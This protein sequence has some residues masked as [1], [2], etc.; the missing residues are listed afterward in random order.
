MDFVASVA[1]FLNEKTQLSLQN[2]WHGAA[3]TMGNGFDGWRYDAPNS[4]PLFEIA[5]PIMTRRICLVLVPRV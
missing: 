3:N 5:N 4:Y 2:Y 1:I